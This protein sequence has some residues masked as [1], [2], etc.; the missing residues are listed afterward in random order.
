[1]F[2]IKFGIEDGSFV[3]PVVE[4]A[5]QNVSQGQI[6]SEPVILPEVKESFGHQLRQT[7]ISFLNPAH[8]TSTNVVTS[9]LCRL[10]PSSRENS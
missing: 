4:E 6:P 7:E 10:T 9:G 5:V 2:L 1:M 3:R 8:T